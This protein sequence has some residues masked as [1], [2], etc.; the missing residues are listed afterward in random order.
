MKRLAIIGASGHG[1]VVADV[2]ELVGWQYI[3]FYDDAWPSIDSVGAWPVVGRTSDLV[4]CIDAYDSF[5]VAIGNNE[6]RWEKFKYLSEFKHNS[7]ILVHPAAIVS[8]YAVL[9]EGTVVMANAVINSFAT[10]CRASIVNTGA[11]IDH[12]CVLEAATHVSPGAN[13]AGRVLLGKMSWVGIGANI[14]QEIVIGDNVI[15]GAGATVVNNIDSGLT[16]V[17]LPARP[18]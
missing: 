9:E 18:I 6:V 4:D 13:L 2:A 8:K 11:T 1:K 5:F 15:V 14:I 7:A 12:D 3:V 17:G 16:V 10:L